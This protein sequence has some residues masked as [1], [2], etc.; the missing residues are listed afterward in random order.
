[1]FLSQMLVIS[2]TLF[3]TVWNVEALA[4]L[5]SRISEPEYTALSGLLVWVMVKEPT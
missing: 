4:E 3:T 2:I 1:M 5:G